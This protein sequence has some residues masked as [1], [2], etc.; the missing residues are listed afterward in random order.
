MARQ[1]LIFC[2]GAALIAVAA[3]L[4]FFVGGTAPAKA[5]SGAESS[6]FRA[7][8]L[9]LPRFASIRAGKAYVRAG[10]A[11]RYPIKWV[12]QR[13]GLP[14]EIVQ[15]FEHWRRI[16]DAEGDEGWIHHS[17]LSGTRTALIRAPDSVPLY[18]APGG[19]SR[20]SAR[21]QPEA[22]VQ[23]ERCEGRWCYIAAQGYQG[24]TERNFLWGIYEHEE[25]N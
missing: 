6:Q 11:L 7:T 16:K 22:L 21:A 24:W 20:L 2:M 18:R 23:L 5:Q 9:P 3:T 13:E 15:E 8:D 14:V 25:L 10:P 17:L 1:F 12:Y 4:M 19:E